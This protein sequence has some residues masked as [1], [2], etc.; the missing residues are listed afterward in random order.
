MK[1]K[2]LLSIA[3]G[4]FLVQLAALGYVLEGQS[5]T[6][7]R[8]VVMQLSLG[9]PRSLSDGFTSFNQSA[10]DALNVWNPYL[11]HLRFKAVL[12]SPVPPG[13]DNEM[14]VAFSSTIFGKS[15]GKD[16]LAITLLSF[17]GTTL[18]E[19]DTLFNTVFTWDSYRGSLRAGVQDFHRVA[20][21]EFGHTLGLDH[22]DEHGQHVTA[23]MNAH[24][25]DIDT[26]QPDDIAGVESLYS[27]G[28]AYRTSI[29]GPVL[30]NLSTRGLIGTGQNV[31]IGGF[32][33]QGSQPATVV[34][35]AIGYSLRAL[36]ITN[37]IS[38]PTI[39]LYDSS[40]HVIASNDDWFTSTNAETIS[41]YHLDPSNSIESAL[42]LTLNPGAY[43]AVVQGYSDSTTPASTGI[44]LVELY[45]LHTTGGRA[46][47]ISTRGQVQTGDNVLIA[48]FIIGGTQSKQVVVRAI[49]PSLATAGIL[50]PL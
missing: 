6:L 49:G 12:D 16:T 43:T 11:A 39:T 14:S 7:D 38:D 1:V 32:I 10:Q 3:V 40:Q 17:R 42:F 23:L 34:L 2:I 21:H 30:L 31:L 37:P 48:G 50:N 4:V 9:G 24:A 35:R 19:T 33:I 36:G 18:E 44:G 47:N 28:P 25:S 46:G 5:W 26:V 41:S 22:P 8:T 29:N 13:N 15:F 20:M 27:S 45:D